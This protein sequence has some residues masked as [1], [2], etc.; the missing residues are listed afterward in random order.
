MEDP[1]V[2][3]ERFLKILCCECGIPIESNPSNTCAQCLASRSDISRGIVTEVILH[4]CRGCQR[5][6]L[7]SGKA[8]NC[9]LESRELMSLCLSKIPGLKHKKKVNGGKFRLI[10]AGWIW[11]EPHSMRLKVRLTVQKEVEAGTILQQALTIT[12]VVRNQ[13][14]E[15]CQA[16]FRAGAW[17]C[18]VQVRQRVKHKRTF[19]FLE[20]L[21]LKH[22]A[23]RGCLSIESCRDGMDFYFG[24]RCKASRF[25]SFLESVVPIRSK[26]SKKLISMDDK[27]NVANYKHTHFLELCPLC[28]DDMLYLPKNVAKT[29]GNISRLVLVKN[30]SS[31]IHVIDPLT[32]QTASISSELYWRKPF[33]PI[34]TAAR[35]RFTKFV[36]L[37]KEAI[38]VRTNV[39]RKQV[40]KKNKS[41][42]ASLIIA[43]ETDLG[44][45]DMQFNDVHSHAGYLLKSG[46]VC[47]GYDLTDMQFNS[48]DDHLLDNKRTSLPDVIVLR[49]LYGAASNDQKNRLWKLKRLDNIEVQETNHKKDDPIT[50]EEDEEDFM[51]EIETDKEMRSLINV[52]NTGMN[53]K[54]DIKNTNEDEE[55]DDDQHIKMNELLDQLIIDKPPDDESENINIDTGLNDD[56]EYHRQV[57]IEGDKA[58]HDGISYVGKEQARNLSDRSVAMAIVKP[59]E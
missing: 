59:K 24:E 22:D 36:V 8:M 55:D 51:R 58:K 17:K 43:R 34:V 38:I 52:Y 45:N 10:D 5:W 20:Q 13:Q 14:C 16:E 40:N 2:A 23:Q 18:L 57:V 46:D 47:I 35:A 42:L 50:M 25:I 54:D 32:G 44:F 11:T 12:F 15:D 6:H 9:D 39:S 33:D 28:K 1:I 26:S 31:W 3:A 27:N 4:Q 29:I 21:I 53:L 41:R 56:W 37:D 48:F 19:L 30:I 7:D 49:K